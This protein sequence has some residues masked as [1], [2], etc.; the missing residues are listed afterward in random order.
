M[1]DLYFWTT[2]N[3]YKVLMFLEEL[4]I[5]YRIIPINISKGEQF[6]SEFYKYR[7]TTKYLQ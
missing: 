5:P 2:P 1:I 3:G 7:Q 4:E 6:G